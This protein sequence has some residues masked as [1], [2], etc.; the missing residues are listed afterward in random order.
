MDEEGEV[1]AA[2]AESG[3]PLLQHAAVKAARE[4]RFSPTCLE[5]KPV[6]LLGTIF[7]NF[8]LR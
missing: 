4:A 5:G 2:Q 3:H 1:I 7:Y 8:I 6:K